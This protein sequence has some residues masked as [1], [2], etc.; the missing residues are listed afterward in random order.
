MPELAILTLDASSSFPTLAIIGTG[1]AS[2]ADGGLALWS[3]RPAVLDRLS[4][5]FLEAWESADE[6]RAAPASMNPAVATRAVRESHRREPITGALAY[7]RALCDLLEARPR[8]A[9]HVGLFDLTAFQ[10]EAVSRAERALD[11]YAGAVVAD[12]VGLGKTFVGLALIERALRRGERVLVVTPAALRHDWRRELA[13]LAPLLP[14]TERG[15]WELPRARPAAP[16]NLELRLEEAPAPYRPRLTWVSTERLGR[17]RLP[18][19]V[20]G[21]YRLLLVDEAHQFRNPATQ[22]HRALAKLARGARVALLTATPVN[23]TPRDLLHLLELFAGPGDFRELGVPDLRL[24]LRENGFYE[25]ARALLGTVVIRRTRPFIATRYGGVTW[26]DRDGRRQE[27][28][29]PRRAPPHAVPYDLARTYGR[30]YEVLEEEITGLRFAALEPFAAGDPARTAAPILR[31]LLL[32]RLESSVEALRRSVARQIAFHVEVERALA[33]GRRLSQTTFRRLFEQGD[34]RDQVQLAL[35]VVLPELPPRE[36]LRT[37]NEAVARDLGAL[38]RIHA[39]LAAIPPER[40]A[41]LT[42]LR[43]L[44]DALRA[45]RVLVFTEFRDTARYLFRELRGTGR[46]AQIDHARAVVSGEAAGTRVDRRWVIERFAPRAN[47]AP[48]PPAREQVDVLIATDVLSEGLNLQD[49]K[50]VVSYDLPWNPVRLLQRAGRVDRLGSPHDVVVLHH[51]QPEAGLE[52]LLGLLAVL[53]TKLRAIDRTVGLDTSFSLSADAE[54]ESLGLWLG[55]LAAGDA[56]A[57]E[58]VERA[59]AEPFEWEERA[60]AEFERWCAGRGTV[61][62]RV[63]TWPDDAVAHVLAPDRPGAVFL[64]RV[65]AEGR[66]RRHL[67]LVADDGPGSLRVDR[68]DALRRLELARDLPVAETRTPG[69]AEMQSSAG[70]LAEGWRNV[71]R[72]TALAHDRVLAT[73]PQGRALRWLAAFARSLPAGGLRALGSELDR[74]TAAL[75]RRQPRGLELSLEGV[76]ERLPPP[77]DSAGLDLLSGFLTAHSEWKPADSAA[78]SYVLCSVCAVD[79]VCEEEESHDPAL[80]ET[81]ARRHPRRHSGK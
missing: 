69:F 55:R 7:A 48:D 27:L 57:L 12:S 3:R 13:A 74:L 53:R 35:G 60:Q 80:N 49:A 11:V 67:W 79:F 4:R 6:T 37:L 70:A 45:E 40:D 16:S 75:A 18:P 68:E 58:E 31:I 5:L 32:K 25:E 34:E 38:R 44:L 77:T 54:P 43:H 26:T 14:P 76:V 10:K 29:F 33:E 63:R 78:T 64:Y 51:F 50:H 21:P 71:C 19:H 41:K 47:R 1:P 17:S 24:A 46:L 73:T 66:A 8:S 36:R 42:A 2:I 30:L 39:A 52:R 81:A 72:A 65:E 22:R 15:A 9:P 59:D 62:A 61:L 20:A 56:S 23:N 28:R